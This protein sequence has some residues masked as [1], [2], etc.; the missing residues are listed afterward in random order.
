MVDLK[1]SKRIL[2]R[3][4][5]GP[6]LEI[7]TQIISCRRHVTHLHNTITRSLWPKGKESHTSGYQRT[8]MEKILLINKAKISHCRDPHLKSKTLAFLL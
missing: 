1:E 3:R 7:Q 6:M 2:G 5:L 8:N 4:L